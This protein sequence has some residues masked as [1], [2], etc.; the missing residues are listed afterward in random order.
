MKPYLKNKLK[1]KGLAWCWWLM[2]VILA[3]QEA[4]IRRI[5]VGSQP[6][7]IVCE[8][9]SRKTLHKNRAAGVVQG[10]GPE[11]KFQYHKNKQNKTKKPQK[12][13]GCGSSGRALAQQVQSQVLTT[14]K[15]LQRYLYILCLLQHCSNWSDGSNPSVHQWTGKQNVVYTHNSIPFTLRKKTQDT[16]YSMGGP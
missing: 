4:E 12:D 1:T 13:W 16:C 14:T 9:L 7:Q 15:K 2:P 11:F 10:E 5:M 6:R 8:T 3:T